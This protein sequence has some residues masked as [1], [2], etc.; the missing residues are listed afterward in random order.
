MDVPPELSE[1]RGPVRIAS[2]SSE[3]AKVADAPRP[4]SADFGDFGP[5]TIA[6]ISSSVRSSVGESPPQVVV[7]SC[8]LTG[9]MLAV[10]KINR[11]RFNLF[12]K[13]SCLLMTLLTTYY[14]VAVTSLCCMAL[15][16]YV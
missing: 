2:F 8:L 13:R 14:G 7:V 4:Y 3:S 9:S 1:R 5:W 12:L 16:S 11:N 15:G 6:D 10:S